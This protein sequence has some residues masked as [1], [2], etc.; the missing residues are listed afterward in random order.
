MLVIMW[1]AF[2]TVTPSDPTQGQQRFSLPLGVSARET[3]VLFVLLSGY[4][5]GRHWPGGFAREAMWPKFKLYVL[6]RTWRIVPAFWAAVTLTILAMLFLGLR[7]PEGTHW[8]EGLPLTWLRAMANYLMITDFWNQVPLSH[9]H[10]TVPMEFH[11]YLLAPLIVLVRKQWLAMGL[12]VLVSLLAVFVLKDYHAPYFP[13][14]FVAAFWAG[15]KRQSDTG[16]TLSSSLKVT[17]PAPVLSIGLMLVIATLGS[18]VLEPSTRNYFVADTLVGAV[19]LPWMYWTDVADRRTPLVRFLRLRAF[20]WLG[21]R[22]Y[23]I[24]LVHAVVLELLWRNIVRP[25]DI[26]GATP[27][28]TVLTPI[29]LVASVLVGVVFFALIER[30][31]ARKSAR[32]GR[33]ATEPAVGTPLT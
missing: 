1:H 6:R 18:G 17:W 8:D 33:V 28:I 5:L 29:A 27:N 25:L 21:D 15:V 31:T 4:L 23:S 13:F 12:A 19:A 9:P 3:L 11:L 22:S 32:A 2:L 14:A 20:R 16:V 24:Y 26:V 30:P 10:W 7:H